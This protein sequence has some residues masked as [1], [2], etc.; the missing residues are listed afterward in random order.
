MKFIHAT[1]YKGL[2][3]LDID[4]AI[5]ESL[6]SK[7]DLI[8]FEI[9]FKKLRNQSEIT[10]TFYNLNEISNSQKAALFSNKD[11]ENKF[12]E[13]IK[14]FFQEKDNTITRLPADYAIVQLS[15]HENF[16]IIFMLDKLLINSN[17]STEEILLEWGMLD[18]ILFETFTPMFNVI[19]LNVSSSDSIS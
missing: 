7:K 1:K 6:L 3:S 12:D 4:R 13:A 15:I 5:E 10:L 14:D 8:L 17:N 16:K 18:H 2:I 19:K 9:F 11:E